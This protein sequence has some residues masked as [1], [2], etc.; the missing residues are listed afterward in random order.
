M[1]DVRDVNNAE[2]GHCSACGQNKD[3][4]FTIQCEECKSWVHYTCGALP[5]YL[6]L[7]LTRTHRKYMC[8]KCSF[9]KYADPDWTAE[10]IEAPTSE[11]TTHQ[12]ATHIATRTGHTLGGLGNSPQDMDLSLVQQTQEHFT[13]TLSRLSI[14]SVSTTEGSQGTRTAKPNQATNTAEPPRTSTTSGSSG[15]HEP[16]LGLAKAR[17]SLVERLLEIF[18]ECTLRLTKSSFHFLGN[19]PSKRTS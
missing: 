16:S 12:T 3:M 10:A 9:H 11:C 15:S 13:P 7:C 18:K 8:E 14:G 5:L 17:G 4:K 1:A 6:L 19:Y 2:P